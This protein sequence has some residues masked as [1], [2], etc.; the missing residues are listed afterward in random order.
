MENVKD[1]IVTH[2]QRIFSFVDR[3]VENYRSERKED[4]IS[5]EFVNVR[6]MMLQVIPDPDLCSLMF[7]MMKK[8]QHAVHQLGIQL[9][10]KAKRIGGSFN[11]ISIDVN[12]LEGSKCDRYQKL[13]LTKYCKSPRSHT[14]LALPTFVAS[15]HG[16]TRREHSD[17]E[18]VYLN[19][20][21][22][23]ATTLM[24][25][26]ITVILRRMKSL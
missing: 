3:Y 12:L 24:E 22:Y 5:D 18:P 9:M 13:F 10:D 19:V 20:D 11:E 4:G 21:D 14:A 17:E 16:M 7:S 8:C 23:A 6:A 15:L 26:F 1:E 25:S 2:L